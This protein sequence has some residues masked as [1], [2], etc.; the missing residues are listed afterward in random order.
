MTWNFFIANSVADIDFF[1]YFYYNTIILI[2]TTHLVR[3]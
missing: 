1:V 2:P 3:D